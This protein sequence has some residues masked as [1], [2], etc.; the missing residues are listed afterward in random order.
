VRGRKTK[1]VIEI[2]Q[3]DREKMEALLRAQKT[4]VGIAR[5]V[6]GIMLLEQSLTFVEAAFQAGLAE[7]HLRKWA[8]RFIAKGLEGLYDKARPG[9][10]PLFPP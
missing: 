2:T 7:R 5:R 4:P 3:S 8:N 9:R 1:L 10:P 6:K